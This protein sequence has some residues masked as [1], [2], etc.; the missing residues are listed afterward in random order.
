VHLRGFSVCPNAFGIQAAV[1]AFIYFIKTERILWYFVTHWKKG[2]PLG[3]ILPRLRGNIARLFLCK[4]RFLSDYV[5]F[6]FSKTFFELVTGM[7]GE[8][9]HEMHRI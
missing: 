5:Y 2:G 7:T 4:M 3:P 9:A 1:L 8:S 6:I